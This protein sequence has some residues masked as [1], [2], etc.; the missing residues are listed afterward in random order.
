MD[1]S[2]LR[3]A[4]A[5]LDRRSPASLDYRVLIATLEAIQ[6]ASATARSLRAAGGTADPSPGDNP[7][8]ELL[9]GGSGWRHAVG[10]QGG[11]F[12]RDQAEGEGEPR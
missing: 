10:A 1:M 5:V 2:F 8:V 6:S 7:M 12:H 11:S 9:I 3:R 4:R